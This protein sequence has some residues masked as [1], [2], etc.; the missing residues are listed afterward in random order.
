VN[1]STMVDDDGRHGCH[2]PVHNGSSHDI[3]P[4]NASIVTTRARPVTDTS[5]G[6]RWV[7]LLSRDL[8]QSTGAVHRWGDPAAMFGA[9]MASCTFR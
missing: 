8:R 7:I 5:P 9:T 1:V 2:D 3:V 4:P 6:S